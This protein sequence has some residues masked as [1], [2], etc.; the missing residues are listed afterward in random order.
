MHRVRTEVGNDRALRY[1]DLLE[2]VRCDQCGADDYDVVYEPR[3]EASQP[4]DI[5][6]AF[7]SSGDEMLI[8]QLVQCR[9]C[10]LRYLN[11]RLRQEII[12][13]AYA[14][15]SDDAFISQ[16]GARERTFARSLALIERAAGKRGRLLDVGTG[17]GS[18]LGV[19]KNRGWEVRGCEPN[20][21]LVEWGQGRYGV[22]ITPGT[23]FDMGLEAA[24]FDV[25][26]LWDVLE[27]TPSPRVILQEC[28]RLLVPGGLLVVNV[29]DAGSAVARLM[30]RRWVFLL[31]VHLYYF[32]RETLGAMLRSTG[33]RVLRQ[34]R[35]WQ[36]LEVQYVLFRMR[37]YVP[38]LPALAGRLLSQVGLG[39]VEVPYWMGQTLVLAKKPAA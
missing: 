25:V 8:D 31:S 7:R 10:G 32:T 4:D 16:A 14:A 30:G 3:Y 35:H 9:E 29:P 12:L 27:H 19:A 26:T 38:V 17:G 20:R 34:Q 11:P 24:S 15:G 22:E 1:R 36:R 18:F 13:E 37:P 5:V 6:Q 33:F 39:R 2:A 21:W 28:S 23:I